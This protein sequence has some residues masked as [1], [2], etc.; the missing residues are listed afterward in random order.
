MHVRSQGTIA[1]LSLMLC[2]ISPLACAL[3]DSEVTDPNGPSGGKAPQSLWD[4]QVPEGFTFAT[5][6]PLTLTVSAN[7]GVLSAET[8]ALEVTRADGRILH[9]GPIRA[10]QPVHLDLVI[11]S[12]DR[13]VDVRIAAGDRVASS[14]VTVDGASAT[15]VFE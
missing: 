8:G 4:V 13:H 5:H 14:R 6:K 1:A 3:G 12:K 10:S 15:E 9:R 2:I 11:P 7:Q